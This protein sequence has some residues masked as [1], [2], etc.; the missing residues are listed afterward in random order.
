MDTGEVKMS[1]SFDRSI[2]D[3]LEVLRSVLTGSGKCPPTATLEDE[4]DQ[5]W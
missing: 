1:Q 4:Y 2:S 3:A 5:K